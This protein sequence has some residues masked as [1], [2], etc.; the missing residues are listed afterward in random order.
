MP[1][2]YHCDSSGPWNEGHIR[3]MLGTRNEIQISILHTQLGRHWD[4]LHNVNAANTP[5][6][7]EFQATKGS[8]QQ[9]ANTTTHYLTH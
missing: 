2:A 8:F 9:E 1:R 6:N 7:T 4:C 3:Q 5:G